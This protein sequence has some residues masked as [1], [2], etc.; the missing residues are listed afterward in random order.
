MSKGKYVAPRKEGKLS[1]VILLCVGAI[2]IGIA[3]FFLLPARKPS[4]VLPNGNSYTA[5]NE[6]AKLT[7]SIAIPGYEGIHLKADSTTQSVG[8]SNPA[9]N[10]CLFR[11]SL[12]LEDGEVLWTSEEIKPG[13]ITDPIVLT[14]TLTK[15]VYPNSVIRYET[16]SMDDSHSPMNGA[17]TKLTLYAD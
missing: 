13:E 10:M 16:F 7:D 2:M 17:T 1:I 5:S 3:I 14:H 9:Q 15:G 12:C 6:E 4:T 8:L 11:I